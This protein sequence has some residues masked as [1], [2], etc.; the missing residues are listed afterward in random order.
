VISLFIRRGTVADAEV[1]V[2]FNA[3]MARETEG[4][5]LDRATLTDGVRQVLSD[6][7]RG[8]YFVAEVEERVVGQLML[9]YEWSD[10]RNGWIWW[11][12]SVYVHPDFR[13]AGVFTALNQHVAQVAR[14]AGVKGIRLYVDAHNLAAQETY[15]RLGMTVSNYLLFERVPLDAT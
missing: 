10:W 13:R 6:E 4:I 14:A 15:R 3:C 11:I 7:S 2:E 1:V 8:L 12:Q 5:E 9:T